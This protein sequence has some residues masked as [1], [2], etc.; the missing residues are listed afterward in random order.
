M[1]H[2]VSWYRLLVKWCSAN[3]SS[4]WFWGRGF[5]NKAASEKEYL[6]PFACVNK[7]I[8]NIIQY[9]RHILHFA[10]EGILFAQ[11]NSISPCFQY[12]DFSYLSEIT[13]I[14]SSC[15]RPVLSVKWSLVFPGCHMYVPIKSKYSL[16][17][18]GVIILPPP[19]HYYNEYLLLIAMLIQPQD[20]PWSFLPSLLPTISLLT[21]SL[22][23]PH[24]TPCCMGIVLD[25]I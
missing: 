19:H 11:L 10:K 12:N 24:K 5:C 23:Y 13:V 3:M 15:N 21:I 9:R 14:Y 17:K 6:P 8:P 1:M 16:S 2:T 20:L 18:G 7:G 4:E 22:F 25:A